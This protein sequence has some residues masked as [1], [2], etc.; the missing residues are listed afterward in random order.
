MSLYDFGYVQDWLDNNERRGTEY[1]EEWLRANDGYSHLSSSGIK[2]ISFSEIKQN[3]FFLS[4]LED[5][6]EPC[7]SYLATRSVKPISS[8]FANRPEVEADGI[9]F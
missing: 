3:S 8:T 4:W 2:Q 1:V 5:V 7:G 9:P 6:L